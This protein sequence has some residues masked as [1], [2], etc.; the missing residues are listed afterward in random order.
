MTTKLIKNYTFDKV[1]KTVTLPDLT[2]F[3]LERVVSITDVTNGILVYWYK[4]PVY[5]GTLAGNV[6]TLSYDTN[7]SEFDNS[8]R[9]AIE[10][11][12]DDFSDVILPSALRNSTATS[13]TRQSLGKGAI[14]IVDVSAIASSPELTVSIEML[15]Q[16]SG[17]WKAIPGASTAVINSI[18]TN[19][20]A[21][22][23]STAETAN[24]RVSAHM[25]LEYRVVATFGG[26]GSI[27]YSVSVNYTN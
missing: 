20:I 6:I 9:L 23:P 1:A 27:T 16:L 21:I 26:T 19:Y 25:P 8:D 10:F 17:N 18:S 4:N 2:A 22:S 5:T 11:A 15:D 7:K 12:V 24:V 3:D 13:S 14:F